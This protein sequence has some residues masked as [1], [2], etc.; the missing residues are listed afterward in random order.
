[1]PKPQHLKEADR[2]A[3]A[4]YGQPA[5]LFAKQIAQICR[6]DSRLIAAFERT[7]EEYLHSNQPAR[8]ERLHS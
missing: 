2:A 1:M 3:L 5:D 8:D 7:R 4:F 6:N